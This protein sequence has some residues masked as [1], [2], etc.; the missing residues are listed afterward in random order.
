MKLF[1]SASLISLLTLTGCTT[2]AHLGYHPVIPKK[3][4]NHITVD[5]ATFDDARKQ[6]QYVGA[7]RNLYGMPIVK[8]HTDDS[9]PNWIADA[10]KV[11]LGNAGY[12]ILTNEDEADYTLEGKILHAFAHTYFIYHGKMHVQIALKDKDRIVFQKEYETNKSAGF[13]WVN[14]SAQCMNAL[15]FNLQEVCTQFIED[16]EQFRNDS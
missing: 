15:E 12:T 1:A 4:A 13:N 11:E 7:L 14:S 3:A 16:F 10:F 5:V 9:V 6:G 8:I 2:K